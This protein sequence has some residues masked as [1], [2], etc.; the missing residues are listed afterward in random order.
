MIMSTKDLRN[1]RKQPRCMTCKKD[2]PV[3]NRTLVDSASPSCRPLRNYLLPTMAVAMK[4]SLAP[5]GIIKVSISIGS[6][7]GSGESNHLTLQ[8]YYENKIEAAEIDISKKTQ[9]L[10]RLEA[11]RNALNTRGER[12]QDHLAQL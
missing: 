9:N 12:V 10:R 1:V 6:A 5:S 11:Q 4:K 2:R 3:S 8:K 7:A